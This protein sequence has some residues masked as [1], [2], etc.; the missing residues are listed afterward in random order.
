MKKLF[1]IDENEKKRI[2]EMH[3]NA[4]KNL[5]L[6]EQT[7][8]KGGCVSKETISSYSKEIA[9]M[10]GESTLCKV[11]G[12]GDNPLVGDSYYGSFY[13]QG[14]KDKNGVPEVRVF[15]LNTKFQLQDVGS[16]RHT[17]Q[18]W[19]ITGT[20]DIMPTTS[21][22]PKDGKIDGFS[23][24][25]ILNGIE[26]TANSRGLDSTKY[27]DFLKSVLGN[28]FYKKTLEYIVNFSKTATSQPVKDTLTKMLKTGNTSE[29]VSTAG[30]TAQ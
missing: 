25:D 22:I 4:T 17:N 11:L 9:A 2:L 1:E 18:G 29:L 3:E 5:Y 26:N 6:S 14:Y 30:F 21:V 24:S 12:T 8:P 15:K 10:G 27:L 23:S 13:L 16:F 20:F 19:I 28:E 7:A